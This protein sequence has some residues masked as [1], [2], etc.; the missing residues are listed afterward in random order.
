MRVLILTITCGQ[1]HNQTGIAVSDYLE[2]NGVDCVTLD[3]I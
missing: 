1:G 3:A 2:K